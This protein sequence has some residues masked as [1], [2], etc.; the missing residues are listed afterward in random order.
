MHVRTPQ[1]QIACCEENNHRQDGWY[2]T[3]GVG[4][5]VMNVRLDSNLYGGESAQNK[6]FQQ[7]AKQVH[8]RKE[9][10][11]AFNKSLKCKEV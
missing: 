1:N 11:N 6:T 9:H 5:I 10:P 3:T 8:S 2:S 4:P 7:T